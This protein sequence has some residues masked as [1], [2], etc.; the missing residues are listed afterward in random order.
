MEGCG[1]VDR[2]GAGV[3][4]TGCCCCCC[5]CCGRGITIGCLEV[6][7]MCTAESRLWRRAG[8]RFKMFPPWRQGRLFMALPTVGVGV[9]EAVTWVWSARGGGSGLEDEASLMR[10]ILGKY[11]GEGTLIICISL[12]KNRVSSCTIDFDSR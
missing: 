6:E 3:V 10:D 9:G 4:A 8:F 12:S 7:D 5:C 2:A 1:V 11:L